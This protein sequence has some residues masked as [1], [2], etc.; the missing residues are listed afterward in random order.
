MAI[1]IAQVKHVFG[2]KGEIT[3]NINYVDE[4]TIVYPSGANTILYNIDQKSQKFIPGSDKTLGTTSMCVSPNRRYV[5][6]AE[7]GAEKATVTIYDLHSLRRRKI[8]SSA[9]IQSNEIVSM[10]F[11]PDSKYLIAQG[12]RPD[13]TLVYWTWEKS[14]VMAVTKTTNATNNDVYQVLQI[15]SF[16][17]YNQFYH[18]LQSDLV[19]KSTVN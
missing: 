17:N 7:K 12:G 15:T 13:W 4:Q 6:V 2:L 11:S 5:A 9:D 19:N 1:A 14:K 8:L 3:G 16:T 18:I 10:A